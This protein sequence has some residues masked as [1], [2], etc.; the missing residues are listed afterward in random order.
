MWNIF[1]LLDLVA[2]VSLALLATPGTAF[3]LFTDVPRHSAF[4]QFPWIAVPVAIVPS[5]FFIHLAIHLK[6]RGSRHDIS[7]HPQPALL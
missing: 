5:I 1:G 4:T 2:A 6:L 3:Q 7:A